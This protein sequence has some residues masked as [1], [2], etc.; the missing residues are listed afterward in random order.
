M[1]FVNTYEGIIGPYLLEE[2][3]GCLTHVWLGDRIS[4]VPEDRDIKETA[5]LKEAKAQLDAYFSGKLKDFSLPIAPAGTDFQLKVWKVLQTI[6]YGE[7]ITYGQLAEQVG[8][9]KASRAVGMANS[10]N[11]L[12]IIIPCHRVIGT[13]HKLTGY[14]GGLDVK[15]KLL[16]LEGGLLF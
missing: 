7:T 9:V 14:T 12:P 15:I 1:P 2:T 13:N 8:N 16:K 6:P 5:L 4:L 3:G 11:P 10:R